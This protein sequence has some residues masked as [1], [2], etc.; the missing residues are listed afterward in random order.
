MLLLVIP[1]KAGIQ[2]LSLRMTLPTE[3]QSFRRPA[4]PPTVI[5][6]AAG[7]WR[8]SVVALLLVIPAKAGIQC[9]AHRMT[10]LTEKA[11]LSPACGRRGPFHGG[12]GP[13]TPCAGRA[14]AR[15]LP[16]RSAA[17]LG[18]RRP[19]PNSHVHV[20]KQR[21]LSPAPAC[22]ARRALRRVVA[23]DRASMH[24]LPASPF[25]PTAATHCRRCKLGSACKWPAPALL[26][27]GLKR[28]FP[29]RGTFGRIGC[30]GRPQPRH[31]AV[32]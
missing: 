9:L 11:K 12:K 5:A 15:L 19:A 2:C 7:A 18:S 14:P 27:A 29:R 20:F 16:R 26:Y 31:N 6:R 22:D 28:P 17:H 8:S 25:H 1:A 13:K 23:L 3:K 30:K 32:T 10:L 21:R 24:Y 4:A